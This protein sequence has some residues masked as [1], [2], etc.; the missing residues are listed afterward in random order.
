[1]FGM[2]GLTSALVWARDLLT[3][4]GIRREQGEQGRSTLRPIESISFNVPTRLEL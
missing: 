4:Q 1:M 3:Y 2:V